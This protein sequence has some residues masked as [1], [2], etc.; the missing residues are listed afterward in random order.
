[1][2]SDPIR[3]TVRFG[4]R[5]GNWRGLLVALVALAGCVSDDGNTANTN[6]EIQALYEPSSLPV[7]RLLLNADQFTQDTDGNNFVDTIQVFVYLFPDPLERQVPIHVDGTCTFT[8]RDEDGREIAQWIFSPRDVERARIRTPPGPGHM[9]VL[10]IQEV[11][12]DRLLANR[13]NLTCQF[14]P[15]DGEPVSSRGPTT[16]PIGPV[17]F[18][19]PVG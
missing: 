14:K 18:G 5:H 13:G 9:F 16:V 15:I 7:Y 17:G 2:T 12:S 8:L 19:V 1:M 6:A 10:N 11:G 3:R 4:D